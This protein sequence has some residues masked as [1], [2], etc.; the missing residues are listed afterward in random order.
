M[1]KYKNDKISIITLKKI[2]NI[3]LLSLT[4]VRL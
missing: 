2:N 1:K 3:F 4:D